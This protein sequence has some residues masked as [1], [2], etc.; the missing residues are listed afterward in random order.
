MKSTRLSMSLLFVGLISAVN[1][2]F[3]QERAAPISRSANQSIPDPALQIRDLARVIRANDLASL[4]RAVVPP[5]HYQLMRQS[6][7]LQRLK[8]ITPAERSKFSEGIAKLTDANAVDKF[9]LEVEPKLIEARP[10]AAGALLI[11][12][13]ALQVALASD[14]SELTPEQRAALQSALPG[15]QKWAASTDFLSSLFMRQA[16]SLLADAARNTGVRSLDELKM[17]SFE[18][19]LAKAGT[20]FAASK[21]ALYIYGL[22]LNAIADSLKVETLNLAGETARVR[23]TITLFDAPISGELDLVL[24]EGRWY[25]KDSVAKLNAHAK[26]I[27]R[28]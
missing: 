2:A 16:F 17:L 8:P 1:P 10:K 5:S 21:Q 24:L 7:E 19:A 11:G 15:I 25:S 28:N 18:Q 23:T 26:Q 13:G 27:A 3:A 4:M 20:L 9:M 22:D 14:D 12:L 6:Y